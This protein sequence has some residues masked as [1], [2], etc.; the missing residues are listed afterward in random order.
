MKKVGQISFSGQYA[1]D[2]GK[3][4]LYVTER[5]VFRRS[6]PGLALIEVAPG[7]DIDGTS[8]RIWVSSRSSANTPSWISRISSTFG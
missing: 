1:Y 3:T 8:W 6:A 2:R 5:C 4:V 7:I